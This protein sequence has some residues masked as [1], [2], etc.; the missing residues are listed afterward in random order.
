MLHFIKT[1]LSST[2][3]LQSINKALEK[4]YNRFFSALQAWD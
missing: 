2:Q 3:R 1:T 4:R